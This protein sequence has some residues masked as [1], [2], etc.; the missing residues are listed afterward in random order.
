MSNRVLDPR[1]FFNALWKYRIQQ[2]EAV[3]SGRP[4]MGITQGTST[5]LLSA[6]IRFIST[7]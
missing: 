5:S 6:V 7:K 2:K 3:L 4:W 1:V